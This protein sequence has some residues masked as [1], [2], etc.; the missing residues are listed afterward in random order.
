MPIGE[1]SRKAIVH[2]DGLLIPGSDGKAANVKQLQFE[3]GK[4]IM[5]SKY[6]QEEDNVNIEF[7][8]EETVMADKIKVSESGSYDL[9]L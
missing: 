3:S 1:D 8:A 2:K 9:Q 4:M 6:G 5:A 7:T